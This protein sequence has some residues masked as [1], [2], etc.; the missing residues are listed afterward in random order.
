MTKIL[1]TKNWHSQLSIMNT[2][3]QKPRHCSNKI[4]YIPSQATF[5]V[6]QTL[7]YLTKRDNP[8]I[9]FLVTPSP[10]YVV[11]LKACMLTD[12]I[13]VEFR[14][15]NQAFLFVHFKQ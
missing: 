6:L 2:K 5:T 12:G 15:W 4:V 1:N 7:E 8:G 14:I 3:A 10:P 13:I 11:L 9:L